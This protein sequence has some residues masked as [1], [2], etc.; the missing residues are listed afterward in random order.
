MVEFDLIL[1][2]TTVQSL[3]M[4]YIFLFIVSINQLVVFADYD[5]GENDYNR[6][7][8]GVPPSAYSPPSQQGSICY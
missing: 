3:Q 6:V 5:Y 7:A 8:P 1:I 4:N 2:S